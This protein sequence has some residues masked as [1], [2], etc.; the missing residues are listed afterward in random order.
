MPAQLF[1]RGTPYTGFFNKLIMVCAVDQRWDLLERT[2]QRY[3]SSCERVWQRST[4]SLYWWKLL[5]SLHLSK[6]R[7]WGSVVISVKYLQFICIADSRS[8]AEGQL[9]R[10]EQRNGRWENI[11]TCAKVF[12]AKLQNRLMTVIKSD[13]YQQDHAIILLYLLGCVYGFMD[14]TGTIIN[15]CPDRE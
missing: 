12:R 15:I 2:I 8:A 13:Y 4:L 9:K 11:E 3:H 5:I 1:W 10:S 7:R 14:Q 6:R